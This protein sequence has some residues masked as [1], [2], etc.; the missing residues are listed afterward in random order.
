[1]NKNA[2]L[3]VF[4]NNNSLNALCE[5]LCS[6]IGCPVVIT[7]NAFHIVSSSAPSNFKNS[8]YF[9]TD[10]H[11][12]L[13]LKTAE[14]IE[15]AFFESDNGFVSLC[16]EE[17]DFCCSALSCDGARLGFIIYIA[18]E[19]A[20]PQFSQR[21]FYEALVSKQFFFEKHRVG[22][23]SN[24]AEE[25]LTA[26]LDG[27]FEERHLFEREAAG[28]FL[29]H[30]SP[31]YFAVIDI[32]RSLQKEKADFGIKGAL[33]AGFHASH[34]FFYKGDVI[35]FLHEDHDISLLKKLS[36]EYGLCVMISEKLCDLYSLKSAFP[37]VISALKYYIEEKAE[38]FVI[39]YSECKLLMLLK[40]ANDVYGICDKEV[41]A[42]FNYDKENDSQLCLTLYTYLICRHSLKETAEKLYTH[43]N[44]VQYRIKKLKDEFMI[45][46]DSPDKLLS[47]IISLSCALL[48]LGY[49]DFIK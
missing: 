5:A 33:E 22:K 23:E 46:P 9:K 12:E 34:P 8:E 30:F 45:D 47:Y 28:T 27:N 17:S 42:V 7:D 43:R 11:S 4:L 20:L 39:K 16:G 38:P 1:M 21:V 19:D 48:K 10:S 15:N 14:N 49:D 31:A 40:A 32:S 18:K 3:D 2:L 29:A 26:L 13:S 6:Q 25:I 44:T 37:P 36:K 24:T 41:E 35:M